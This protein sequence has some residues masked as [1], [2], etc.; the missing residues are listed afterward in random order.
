MGIIFDDFLCIQ[1]LDALDLFEIRV[2]AA[3]DIYVAAKH[4]TLRVFPPLYHAI[5]TLH[6]PLPQI[7]RPKFNEIAI[8]AIENV[9]RSLPIDEF[10]TFSPVYHFFALE[11]DIDVVRGSSENLA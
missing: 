10:V 9:I 8:M 6:R 5:H 7:W 1:S 4:A 3:K 2:I 11:E